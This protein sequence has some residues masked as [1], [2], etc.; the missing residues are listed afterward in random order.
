M[1]PTLLFFFFPPQP[2]YSSYRELYCYVRGRERTKMYVCIF[3]IFT[4]VAIFDQTQRDTL[5][6][7]AFSYLE[8]PSSK[9]YKVLQQYPHTTLFSYCTLIFFYFSFFFILLS[10]FLIL[11]SNSSPIFFLILF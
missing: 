10:F 6:R 4:L 7:E 9:S 1:H 11:F 8:Y 5:A 3:I 2:S